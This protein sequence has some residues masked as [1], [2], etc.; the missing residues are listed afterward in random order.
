M[1]KKLITFFVA[2]IL[3]IFSFS[4]A[5]K[6]NISSPPYSPIDRHTKPL[7]LR[8]AIV[9][10]GHYGD[11]VGNYDKNYQNIIDL[12]N[13]EKERKG[14]DYIFF[15]GDLTNN[16]GT[17]LQV[18]KNKYL[19]PS[20]LKTPF[21]VIKG[22][23]DYAT[24]WEWKLVW[25]YPTDFSFEDKDSA[26]IL[27]DTSANKDYR[28]FLCADYRWFNAR[29]NYYSTKKNI[30]VF[31]H[32]APFVRK[33]EMYAAE[34]L[35]VNCGSILSAIENHPNIRA[36]FHGHLHAISDAKIVNGKYHFWDG[37][38]GDGDNLGY[39]P[40]TYRIVEVYEDDSIY[41]YL[42]SLTMA[43]IVNE[44]YVKGSP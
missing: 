10:D 40:K 18:I 20:K 30:F 22:N 4:C 8:F 41:T 6:I 15:L 11:N 23:H 24:D 16:D 29:L 32:I 9:S 27:A 25:G 42:Y 5:P 44:Y 2:A 21:Y 26:F 17:Y 34:K 19:N 12:L 28:Q 13:Q 39:I 37:C 38:F 1:I 33:N 36:S 14:L 35:Q 3:I 7:K 31:M 43:M